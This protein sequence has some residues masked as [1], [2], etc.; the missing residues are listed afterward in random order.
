VPVCPTSSIYAEA[1]VPENFAA[2]TE[3]NAQYFQ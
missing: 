3:K 1:E 2:F